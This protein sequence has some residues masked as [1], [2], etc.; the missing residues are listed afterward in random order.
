MRQPPLSE[1]GAT[2]W[3]GM[4]RLNQKSPSKTQLNKENNFSEFAFVLR[5]RELKISKSV[6]SSDV[7]PVI[8]PAYKDTMYHYYIVLN[9][10]EPY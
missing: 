9:V 4:F 1:R 5:N 2:K 6:V 8:E 10:N 3:R 7:N